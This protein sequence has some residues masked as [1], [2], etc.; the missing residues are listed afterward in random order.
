MLPL[1]VSFQEKRK[2]AS[3][4]N[5]DGS[6]GKGEERKSTGQGGMNK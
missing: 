6:R 2:G 1:P 5:E 3:A 4:T